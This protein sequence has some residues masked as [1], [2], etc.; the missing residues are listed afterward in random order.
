MTQSSRSCAIDQAYSLMIPGRRYLGSAFLLILVLVPALVLY[1]SG[2]SGG[3]HLDDLPNLQRLAIEDIGLGAYLFQNPVGE[4]GRPLTYLTFYLQKADYPGDPGAFLMVNLAIHLVNTALLFWLALGLARARALQGAGW[5]AA[6]TAVL[7][8]I[9]PVHVGTVLYVVQRMTLLS[10][11]FVLFGCA[12]Y[13]H[14]RLRLREWN[15]RAAWLLTLW[16]GVAYLGVFAKE[17]AILA[18][19]ALACL[20]YFFLAQR[21]PVPPRWWRWSLFFGPFVLVALYLLVLKGVQFHYEGRAFTLAERLLSESRILWDYLK[22][23]LVPDF[24]DLG[25]FHDDFHVSRGWGGWEFLAVAGWLLAVSLAVALRR[26]RFLWPLSFGLSWFL[27]LHLLES[28]VVPL[29]LYFEHRNYL[30]SVGLVL[31]LVLLGNRVVMVWSN[32]SHR[33]LLGVLVACYLAWLG[34]LTAVEARAWGHPVRFAAE[35]VF[36]HPGSPRAIEELGQLFVDRGDYQAAYRLYDRLKRE[37]PELYTPGVDLV[38]LLLSCHDG[39]IPFQWDEQLA[40][41]F[42]TARS[43][44][45]VGLLQ[46]I[47]ETVATDRC[48]RISLSDYVQLV[49]SLLDNPGYRRDPRLW[50]HLRRLKALALMASGNQKKA[51]ATLLEGIHL[52]RVEFQYLMLAATMAYEAQDGEAL[53]RLYPLLRSRRPPDF[54]L[55]RDQRQLL[56]RLDAVARHD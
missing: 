14:A 28:T 4:T 43:D 56:D 8:S 32:S 34:T 18:G 9:L 31:A 33:R 40:G 20:E 37:R 44:R 52:E 38:I 49:D 27:L 1:Q 25:F 17:N 23:V 6:A 30:P 36:R 11:T 55:T 16:V 10:A 39:A 45:A 22:I 21:A 47:L 26:H 19:L 48:D 12:G 24:N 51:L 41:H 50:A 42:R 46:D 7:W 2:L 15:G 5:I 13:V 29:E 54:F 53:G 35:A 3:F